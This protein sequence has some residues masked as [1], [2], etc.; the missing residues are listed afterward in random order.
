MLMPAVRAIRDK[1]NALMRVDNSEFP[2]LKGVDADCPQFSFQ[3]EIIRL[4]KELT[5][6]LPIYKSL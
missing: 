4:E 5:S 3:H 6:L 1:T 2:I